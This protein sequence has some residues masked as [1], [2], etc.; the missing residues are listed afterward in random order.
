MQYLFSNNDI[1]TSGYPIPAMANKENKLKLEAY[2][3]NDS[4][5]IILLQTWH[6]L[7]L[8]NLSEID[9]EKIDN[10]F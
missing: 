10:R 8:S 4:T 6:T 5:T 2:R 7:Y 9:F 3:M 1:Y